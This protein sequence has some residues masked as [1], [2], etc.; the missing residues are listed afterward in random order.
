MDEEGGYQCSSATST[1]ELVQAGEEETA[2]DEGGYGGQTMGPAV[3]P[4]VL[5][6]GAQAKEDGVSYPRELSFC[7]LLETLVYTYRFAWR[8]RCRRLSMQSQK[9]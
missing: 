3:W 2:D 6:G 8:R 4:A 7:Q 5:V 1:E 9:V